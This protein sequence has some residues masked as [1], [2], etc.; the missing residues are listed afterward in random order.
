MPL[1]IACPLSQ[2]PR[3][4]AARQEQLSKEKIY[5]PAGLRGVK[6]KMNCKAARI[7]V[8][9]LQAQRV[10]LQVD[11]IA[12]GGRLRQ[13]LWGGLHRQGV[14]LGWMHGW[15]GRPEMG[16]RLRAQRATHFVRHASA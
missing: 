14:V 15:A 9:G 7:A 6:V 4:N 16:V 1:E 12:D 8:D 5:T 3:F 13:L 10:L 11:C 2:L